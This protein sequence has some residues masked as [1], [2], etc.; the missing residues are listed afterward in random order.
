MQK[1]LILGFGKSGKSAASYLN[2]RGK[3]V[4][5]Y[6][7]NQEINTF[8][9]DSWESIEEVILSP[10]IP[11][12][13]PMVQKANSMGCKVISEVELALREKKNT[14]IGVTGTNGKTT[15]ILLLEHFF[16]TQ[17]KKAKAVG[18]I[19]NP[20]TSEEG[21]EIL[22]LELS[23]FQLQTTFSPSLDL[24]ILLNISP[25]H[26]DHHKTYKEYIEA[27]L[28]IFDLL[29]PSGVMFTQSALK[30]RFFST[31]EKVYSFSKKKKYPT[32]LPA[33]NVAAAIEAAKFFSL[34][35]PTCLR[36]LASFSPPAHRME[37]IGCKKGVTWIND[38]KATT[39]EAVLQGVKAIQ[40]PIILIVGGVDKNL[41]FSIWKKE[42]PTN[43][44]TIIAMGFAAKK[45][46]QS[47]ES[48][49]EVTLAENLQESVTLAK[50]LAN[51]GETI[52]LSPGCASFDEYANFEER[53]NAFKEMAQIMGES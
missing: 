6:D 43:I 49:F 17:G 34:D 25:N 22:L 41:S 19:G 39:P 10:G 48:K 45:I 8:Q 52:L 16:Q 23:S 37:V 44:K 46:K 38:S 20:I 35:I 30:K 14:I 32:H 3:E 18:N 31:E 40:R 47:L 21:S 28:H 36:S 51:E 24:A 9:E 5:I 7:K 15:T 33:D 13:H 29:K 53:G 2:K 50:K 1:T 11:L 27:K 26:L 4:V 42:L 12:S